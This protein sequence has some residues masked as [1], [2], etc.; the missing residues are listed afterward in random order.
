MS[1]IKSI[2][3]E[4]YWV[5]AIENDNE[6]LVDLSDIL[7]NFNPDPFSKTT[8]SFRDDRARIQKLVQFK[9]YWEIQLI[10]IRISDTAGIADDDGKYTFLHLENGEYLGEFTSILYDHVEGIMGISRNMHAFTPSGIEEYFNS[11]LKPRGVKIQLRPVI[12]KDSLSRIRKSKMIRAISL[13]LRAE[14]VAALEGDS[15][16]FSV[17]CGFNK[18][19]SNTI[20]ISISVGRAGKH[21]SLNFE[22][23]NNLITEVYDENLAENFKVAIL[24]GNKV[25][26]VDLLESKLTKVIKL[27]Y[28]KETPVNHDRIFE[29]IMKSYENYNRRGLFRNGE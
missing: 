28:D 17:I 22:E 26:T 20:K 21:E 12:T 8:K 27:K 5:Y 11:I 1:N 10:R 9:N 16:L 4:Y 7:D 25:E 18:F 13:S 15:T 6:Y 14:D 24:E 23:S 2:G 3:I 19:S 29:S